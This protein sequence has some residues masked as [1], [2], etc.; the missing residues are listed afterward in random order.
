VAFTAV[1]RIVMVA[2]KVKSDDDSEA[3]I[4]ARSKSNIGPDDGGFKYH[5]EQVQ[6]NAFPGIEAA[7]IAWGDSVEGTASQLLTDPNDG[8]SDDEEGSARDSAEDFLKELLKDGPTPTKQVE[9]EAKA[10]GIAWRTVR[11]ASDTLSV[12]KQK[13]MGGWYW[14]LSGIS[15]LSKQLVQLVQPSDDGQVGQHDGQVEF[16]PGIETTFNEDSEVL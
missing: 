1:A 15:N 10:A 8:N 2:A 14:S 13:S 12:K 16:S 11:R 4:L 7:R 6:V 5:L 3:R 9:T